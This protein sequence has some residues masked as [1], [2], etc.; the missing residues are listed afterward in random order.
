M[1]AIILVSSIFYI[2]G[3]KL[4]NK[5][6]LS[7]KSDPVEKVIINKIKTKENGE[8][9]KFPTDSQIIKPDSLLNPVKDNLPVKDKE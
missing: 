4:G 2:I 7:G 8:T 1:K 6:E 9:Y 3:L 5:I